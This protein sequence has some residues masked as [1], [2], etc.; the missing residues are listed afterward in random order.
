MQEVVSLK[1][2]LVFYVLIN[3]ICY[4][5]QVKYRYYS[6]CCFFLLS[7]YIF[8]FNKKTQKYL[9]NCIASWKCLIYINYRIR[10]RATI[11]KKKFFKD[12]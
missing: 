10:S 3:F 2:C 4:L 8:R 9:K 12:F 11:F 1:L 5:M 6:L 7:Q